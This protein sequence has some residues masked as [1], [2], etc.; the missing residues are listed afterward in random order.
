MV[1]ERG[2]ER[3]A[4]D[5]ANEDAVDATKHVGI[6]SVLGGIWSF[7]SDANNDYEVFPTIGT[8][9]GT[10]HDLVVI[11]AL[12][13]H[14]GNPVVVSVGTGQVAQRVVDVAVAGMICP[15]AAIAP[16]AGTNIGILSR[17]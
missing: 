9:A 4:R 15:F 11:H 13:V 17:R 12:A 14:G 10:N 8:R 3:A 6:R 16:G 1:D 5:Q 7:F 2:R